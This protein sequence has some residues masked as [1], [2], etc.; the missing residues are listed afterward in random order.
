MSQ[1]ASLFSIEEKT[2][3]KL[4]DERGTKELVHLSNEHVTFHQTHEG[5]TFVLSKGQT[6]DL[7]DL[8]TEIFYPLLSFGK[9]VEL[10]TIDTI[11]IDEDDLDT[12][13]PVF[14]HSAR[15]VTQ[16]S[17]LLNTIDEETFLVNFDADEMNSEDVYPGTWNSN[18]NG[19]SPF[20]QVHLAEDFRKLKLFFEQAAGEGCYI[21]V[22]IN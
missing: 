15:K 6:E 19:R 22:F 10:E 1:N 5:L 3:H 20:N 7:L 12:N 17:K 8:V 16:I 13:E 9:S 4:K 21:L 18:A 11:S 14:Y 2:F